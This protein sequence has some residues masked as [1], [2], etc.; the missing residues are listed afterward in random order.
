MH[1]L[2]AIQVGASRQYEYDHDVLI[3]LEY[4]HNAHYHYGKHICLEVSPSS[5]HSSFVFVVRAGGALVRNLR[6]TGLG[7]PETWKVR[8][9][10]MNEVMDMVAQDAS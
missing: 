7:R 5:G 2:L 9:D 10:L 3:E 4:N 6:H 1:P 8:A